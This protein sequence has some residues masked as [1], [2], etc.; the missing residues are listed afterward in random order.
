MKQ[1]LLAFG[2]TS[3][4]HDVSVNSAKTVY[5]NIDRSSYIVDLLYISKNNLWYRLE[6]FPTINSNTWDSEHEQKDI[7]NYVRLLEYYDLV[8]PIFHGKPGEDGTFQGLLD[9]FKIPY[10]GCDTHTSSIS[11]DKSTTKELLSFHD[12]PMLPFVTIRQDKYM[13]EDVI[14]K[15]DLPVI[16]KPVT[17]GSSIGVDVASNVKE[18][19]D[20]IHKTFKY[21]NK[22][23]IEPFIK[24]RE[25]ECAVYKTDKIYTSSIGEILTSHSFYSYEAKYEDS[26]SK[27][28]IPADIPI[29]ITKK[30]K[31][32]AKSIF[33]LLDGKDLS[34]ID[35]FYD[36]ANNQ[37]Y[38]NEINTIPGFT[39]ISMYPKL[40]KNDKI[41]FKELLT[42]L[43]EFN[44]Q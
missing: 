32:T 35:F 9:Y 40:W 36:E 4:E 31:E 41:S 23:I 8:F 6:E 2:G 18:L 24:Y 20:K 17:G 39:E 42:T 44:L 14:S 21:S 19:D 28:V 15:M 25:L 33:Y 16:I 7:L 13:I 22:L 1:V 10:I 26:E 12:I 34:R 30:I 37:I 27:G 11:I 3:T 38:F 43:I 29:D 5:D